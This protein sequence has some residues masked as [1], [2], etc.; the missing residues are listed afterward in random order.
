MYN[1]FVYN[2]AT[3]LEVCKK[4]FTSKPVHFTLIFKLRTFLGVTRMKIY[5]SITFDL[6]YGNT[7]CGVFKGEIQNQKGFWLKIN[8]PKRN[9]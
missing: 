5:Y 3:V 7:G 9:Y 2:I 1:D 4:Q 6:D 8:I